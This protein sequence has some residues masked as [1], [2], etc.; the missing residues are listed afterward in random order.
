[1]KDAS[2]RWSRTWIAAGAGSI[3]L[4][5]GAAW[6]WTQR[7]PIATSYIDDALTAR[8]I[9]AHYRLTQ[10][11]FRTQR[12]EDIRIGDPHNPDLT[13]DWAE[14]EL[15]VGLSGVR[16]RAIDAGGVRLR[17]R[18]ANGR[19][20]LGSLDRLLPKSE[21][22]QPFALPDIALTA[23]A[24]QFDLS[25]P[26]G[27]VKAR[28]DGAGGLKDGFRGQLSLNSERLKAGGCAISTPRAMLAL[29]VEAGR[30]AVRGPVEASD[31]ACPGGTLL[32]APR[33]DIAARS[34]ADLARW[35]GGLTIK[36]GRLAAP[37][38]AVGGLG[39]TIV[40]DASASKVAGKVN[41]LAEQMRYADAT[42]RY[43]AV[44]ADY[45]ADPRAGAADVAGDASLSDV[46]LDP[47]LA[48]GFHQQAAA[49][50]GTPFAPVL[51]AWSNAA[52]R[53]AGN[54][55]GK[56]RFAIHQDERGG[57]ARIEKLEANAFGGG[58]LTVRGEGAEGLSWR[59][60][61]AGAVVNATIDLEGGGFPRLSMSL[62]QA[63]PGAPL[64]GAATL[65]P[66]QAA[67]ARLRLAPVLIAPAIGGGTAITTRVAL[68]GPLADG[69]VAG[70]DLPVSVWLGR[71][72]AFAVNQ[73]C[74][75]LAFERLAIAG[76]V[77]G[78]S[79]LPLCP[80][81]GALV[82]R[83]ASGSLY[84][85]ARIAAPRLRGRVGDQ[86]LTMEARSLVVRVARPGFSLDE[87]AVRLGDPAS[88]TRLDVAS[89]AGSVGSQGLAGRF[90]GAAGKIGA[91]PLLI[92]EGA[93]GWRLQGSA[94]SIDGAIRVA[95]AE[96]ADPRFHPLI[97]NDVRVALKGGQIDAA[98]T[99]REPRSSLPVARVAIRHDLSSGRGDARLD[100]DDLRFGKALQPEAVTPLTLG[101]I[102]NVEGVLAGQGR[103]RWADGVVTSD[104]EFHTD[105]LNLAAAFGPVTGLKG[106]IRFT[107]LLDLVTAPDQ[108][109]TIAEI[110]PG[111]AVTNGVIRYRI[112]PDRKL[113]V[114]EGTWPFAGGTLTL[115]PTVLDM[116]QPVARRLTF[117]ID[118]LD[119]A[120]FVQQLE[121]K[122][123]AVTGK[124]DGTL[125]I[126]FDAQGG[127]IENGIL[128]VRPPGGTLSYVGD[129]TN[130]NLG[131]IARIAFDALKSM[132]Y[133]QLTVD[134]NGS[135]DGEIV[136]RVRFD[137]TNDKP[138]ETAKAGG[139]VG[140]IL[141]PITR[142]PFRFN[143]TITAPF[144]GLVNSAQTFID[145]SI[146]LRNSASAALL[147][148]A[149]APP[150]LPPSQTPIQPR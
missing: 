65:A 5:G 112:L 29:S 84:G 16:V 123:L 61:R 145:P 19:L 9:P 27:M 38:I 55:D 25:T 62:R 48:N 45:G 117:R 80:I 51:A 93:G 122:N 144:R 4:A 8:N 7:A 33:M 134:L 35:R 113:S 75:P 24:L 102:A 98:A 130:A 116:G 104:G 40:F 142:L 109:V 41:L 119:A 106:T 73:R 42:A 2:R 108:R 11:G 140:R 10:V 150:A 120:T 126:I 85:G 57:V 67:G 101:M 110:N 107:D 23:R 26:Q 94:L 137:G 118:G 30:P 12:I 149:A 92:S 133:Q 87:L 54:I 77:I 90:D 44:R 121:F 132:R 36:G 135:L 148:P 72:G 53:A 100:V 147:P 28:L 95:D 47:K 128:R 114:A 58:H 111:V 139:I 14:I 66:Y 131:R 18:I 3:L 49:T 32:S 129:V 143:I 89:L 99:L 74:A 6:L 81:D 52:R 68:D 96:Q 88:P 63:V 115:E 59:W 1:M 69:R 141:A 20:S 79:S 125:P 78:R 103:I 46:Q 138:Q 60:P 127:R 91:V 56:A 22:A 124:F 31:I 83:R 13:A 105:A 136:S 50:D 71:G 15:A 97:A 82:G 146:V 17:G 43:G 37:D 64:R 34:D 70:L 76:T 86:P 21:S 39:G